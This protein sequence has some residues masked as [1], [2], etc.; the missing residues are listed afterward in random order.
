MK[1]ALVGCALL[2]TFGARRAEAASCSFNSVVPVAF[3]AY[4]VFSATQ[5]DGV[6]S[7]TYQCSLLNLLDAIT[8]NLSTGS[9][10]TYSARAMQNGASSLSYNLYMDAARTVVWGDQSNGTSNYNAALNLLAVSLSIYGR[11]PARQNAKAGSY[12]DT[13]V[14][15]LLF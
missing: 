5:T 9:S 14:V 11:I 13:V 7:I 12:T 3:G 6:G 4:D 10:G 1:A 15:T 2:L 8:I